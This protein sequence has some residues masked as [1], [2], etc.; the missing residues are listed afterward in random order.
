MC[1]S[2]TLATTPR[3]S[4]VV[5]LCPY[6]FVMSTPRRVGVGIL[7]YGVLISI[8]IT[9]ITMG[10]PAQIFWVA[11]FLFP[12]SLTFDF[13]YELDIWGQGQAL[14]AFFCCYEFFHYFTK[15]IR[16][17]LIKHGSKLHRHLAHDL[18]MVDLY[19]TNMCMLCRAKSCYSVA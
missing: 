7:F 11:C 2:Q 19:L 9:P 4:T 12:R 14:R 16:G 13:C 5:V 15:S 17:I 10:P 6:L 8:G 3:Q 1:E 18:I